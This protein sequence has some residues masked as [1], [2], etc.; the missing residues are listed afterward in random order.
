MCSYLRTMKSK[1]QQKK[2]SRNQSI[3]ESTANL[4]YFFLSNLLVESQSILMQVE[5]YRK[6][7]TPY[8]WIKERKRELLELIE[9]RRNSLVLFFFFSS[10]PSYPACKW[11]FSER[12]SSSVFEWQKETIRAKYGK[13]INFSLCSV[14]LDSKKARPNSIAYFTLS[15]SC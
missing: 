5:R 4:P 8:F 13:E 12:G 7:K 14:D 3:T 6:I 2:N 10:I 11:L 1:Y 9:S 15:Q